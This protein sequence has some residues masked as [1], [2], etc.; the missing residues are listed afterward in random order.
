MSTE[1]LHPSIERGFGFPSK[2]IANVTRDMILWIS[3]TTA[4]DIRR[5]SK[6]ITLRHHVSRQKLLP[7]TRGRGS[8]GPPF[9]HTAAS[10][11]ITWR[12]SLDIPNILC[13]A[14]LCCAKGVQIF[15]VLLHC[16]F[17]KGLWNNSMFILSEGCS[18]PIFMIGTVTLPFILLCLV[19]QT[20]NSQH[21]Q[22]WWK[23]T[24][25][26][27]YQQDIIGCCEWSKHISNIAMAW[28]G[29]NLIVGCSTDV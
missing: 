20:K 1:K 28:E 25:T 6:C 9:C 21:F 24:S 3:L 27:F 29:Q 5:K 13:Y 4:S 15:S 23:N 8:K 10:A 2:H 17:Q 12:S 19:F 11:F 7:M 16:L 14:M 22:M 26:C 18:V